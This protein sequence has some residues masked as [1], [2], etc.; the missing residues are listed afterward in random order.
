MNQYVGLYPY[1]MQN[2]NILHS[3]SFKTVYNLW[4]LFLVNKY[5]SKTFDSQLH[6]KKS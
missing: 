1:N 4:R 2:W 5:K 3:Y 6:L